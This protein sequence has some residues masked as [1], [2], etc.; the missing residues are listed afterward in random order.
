MGGEDDNDNHGLEDAQ[1]EA[2]AAGRRY[3][4]RLSIKQTF[5]IVHDKPAETRGQVIINTSDEPCKA[6]LHSHRGGA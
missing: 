5:G 1:R 4:V 3:P 6:S 2:P